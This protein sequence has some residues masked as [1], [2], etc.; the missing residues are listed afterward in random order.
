MANALKDLKYQAIASVL[1]KN[2]LIVVFLAL[3]GKMVLG[4]VSESLI[5]TAFLGM[6]S[7]EA[8]VE[9]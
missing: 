1:W 6:S 8:D 2:L 7:K 4:D 5:G 3:I 9:A